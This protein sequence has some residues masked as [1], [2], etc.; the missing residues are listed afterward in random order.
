MTGVREPIPGV[1]YPD[2]KRLSQYLDSGELPQISL[3]EA[4]C[5]SFKTH[6][7]ATALHTPDG[8]VGYAELDSLTDRFAA[9]LLG[10]GLEPLDRV[11]FQSDN[12]AELVYAFV[13][14]L[15]AGLIPVCTLAAH[16]EKE[17]GFL[18]CHVDA[19]LHIVQ[20]SGGGF[21]LEEFA[22]GMQ[23]EIL[24]IRHIVSLTGPARDG[25]MAMDELINGI[26]ADKARVEVDEVPRD[27][28][29]VGVFQLSGGTTGTP[30]V[31]PRM[32]ND[33]LLNALLTSEVLGFRRQ[34]VMFMP[35]PIIHNACMICCLL[36][37]LLSGAS[38]A[39]A[40][41]MRPESWATLFAQNKPSFLFL[42]RPLLPRLEAALEIQPAALDSIRAFWSADAAR[43]IRHKYNKP[44]YGMFGMAEGMNM[45]CR[46]GD[47]DEALD[48]T[49][50]HPLSRFDEARLVRPGT[51]EDVDDEEIGEL[52]CR[53][54]YTLAGY[55]NA[56]ERNRE[57]FTTDGYYK[58]GDL[59][60]RRK[61]GGRHY[62]AFAG[63]TKDVVDRGSEKIN[64]EEV[65]TAVSTHAAVA[66]CAV[67]GMPDPVLGERVC[68]YIVLRAGKQAPDVP[69][70]QE[71]LKSLGF[72][73]FK[74]PE[75]IEYIEALPLTKV[76]KLDKASL[77]KDISLRL[78]QESGQE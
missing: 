20:G 7:G 22:L 69:E 68:V 49:V 74:W 1:V 77:R 14:C 47:P 4:L 58:P 16:R 27:P 44:A 11:L 29:Q 53:G 71:H 17:I 39:I 18:G 32:Q 67:I 24:T 41:D 37:T 33:Y 40:A 64:C 43:V 78:E 65:E 31:I 2:P 34:D 76:G 63:R 61:I 55:Y 13:A 6:A 3:A 51:E 46:E 12:C 45:Y 60:V 28:F 62:Y 38:F 5:A 56:P 72:A 50:G 8:P 21:D 10:L 30:K 42:I 26:A 75:R 66:G 23:K 48:W 54:P 9:A 35:M 52:I 70:L 15:K 59:M 19:R 25:V 57:A 36:P 73:K